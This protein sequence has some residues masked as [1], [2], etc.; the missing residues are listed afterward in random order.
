MLTIKNLVKK[1]DAR[2]DEVLAVDD[3][4]LDIERGEFFTMLGPSGCGKTTTLRCV[5]GLEEPFSGTIEI[6]GITV[7]SSEASIATR[8][9]ERDIS[10]VFQ[11]YAIWPHM[12]VFQNV[13][14]P[15]EA[16]GRIGKELTRSK[17]NEA[18]DAVGLGSMGNR[19]ATQL[20][21][22]QQ[23]RVALAR[24]IVKD[25]K[26][27]LFDEPLSN[28][29]AEL[30][31]QM[32]A[33]LRDIQRTLGKTFIYV[34]HDQDEALSL[35][36]R[37]ALMRSGKV[38]EIG[39]PEDLYLRPTNGFTSQFIGNVTLVPCTVVERIAGDRAVV[40]T[41]FA[42]RLVAHCPPDLPGEPHVMMRP[43]HVK[44]VLDSSPAVHGQNLFVGTV[45]ARDFSGHVRDHEVRFA[46][47]VTLRVQTLS[48]VD[49][50]EGSDFT[51]RVAEENCVVVGL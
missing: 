35:S 9:H 13:A 32:R 14:F 38:V 44:P 6:D 29:D 21:G 33:E 30:R 47:D 23:Q 41:S 51:F 39:R 31:I 12:S 3:V 50:A 48:D 2:G 36:D 26:V 45:M 7:Y 8:P 46:G 20:S 16:K 43:E 34:T 4:S 1:F 15:L 42:D 5:A 27:L 22:G 10:M 18:L 24:A 49:L 40:R 11:S 25:A 28:L 19:S 17:V 37:I